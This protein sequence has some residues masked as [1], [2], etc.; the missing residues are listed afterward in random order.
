MPK[1]KN[2]LFWEVYAFFFFY[3]FL[4]LLQN[5]RMEVMHHDINI[6]V[7]IYNKKNVFV[8]GKKHKLPIYY[9]RKSYSQ[10]FRKS[11]R[12]SLI[13]WKVSYSIIWCTKIAVKQFY[14][15]AGLYL[16]CLLQ[17]NIG[18]FVISKMSKLRWKFQ[19]NELLFLTIMMLV[20][21]YYSYFRFLIS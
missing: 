7:S 21:I 17:L 3:F 19:S 16:Y 8:L 1:K 13:L 12:F 20:I 6:V 4:N 15:M 2:I 5:Q 14:I 11:L 9:V 18:Y 10:N